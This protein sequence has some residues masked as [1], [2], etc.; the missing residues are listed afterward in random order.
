MYRYIN[1]Y[2][3]IYLRLGT[4]PSSRRFKFRTYVHTYIYIYN[5]YTDKNMY[6]YMHIYIDIYLRL[7]ALDVSLIFAFHTYVSNMSTYVMC[8]WINICLEKKCKNVYTNM[9]LRFGTRYIR[10]RFAF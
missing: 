3:Y 8:I 1:I 5:A 2:K 10:L 4:R 7:G 6:A 9:H